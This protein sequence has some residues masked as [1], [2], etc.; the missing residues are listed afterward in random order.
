MGATFSEAAREYGSGLHYKHGFIWLKNDW[1]DQDDWSDDPDEWDEYEEL[2]EYEDLDD[3]DDLD[4]QGHGA[5]ENLSDFSGIREVDAEL[6]Y[7]K[8]T[9][10]EAAG[11]EIRIDASGIYEGCRDY[12]SYWQEDGTLKIEEEFDRALWKRIGRKDAGKLVIEIP[13]DRELEDVSLK[14]GAGEI[15]IENIKAGCLD[16][17]I[18]AGRAVVKRFQTKDLNVDCGAGQ[19]KLNGDFTRSAEVECGVG[20]LNLTLSGTQEDYDYVLKSGMGEI[21]LGGGRYSGLG[22]DKKIMNN[23]GK[24]LTIDCSIGTAE[25]SFEKSL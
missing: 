8:L 25:V 24:S 13:K 19:A 11:D 10:R 3:Y 14:I 15:E 20:E 4:D 1:D 17:D 18:G 2:D 9:V 21:Q 7:L 5:E 6:D 22:V 12:I 16:L 23:A